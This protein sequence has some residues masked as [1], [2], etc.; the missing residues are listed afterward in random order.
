MAYDVG[1][2]AYIENKEEIANRTSRM[3]LRKNA[4]GSIDIYFSEA[5]FWF[6]EELASDSSLKA[7]FTYFRPYGPTEAY[8]D[9]SW[10]L[11]D[12]EQVK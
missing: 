2:R 7:W 9:K 5:S 3:D 1:T 12:I 4:G 6:R 8:F 11:P 10:P